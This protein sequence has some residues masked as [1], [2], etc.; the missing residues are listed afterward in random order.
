MNYH[1]RAL[2]ELFWFAGVAVVT[3]L[4]QTFLTFEPNEIQDWRLWA[5][6][7]GAAAVRAFAGAAIAWL[8]KNSLTRAEAKEEPA[9]GFTKS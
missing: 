5:V 3:V 9:S 7:L 1:Y 6:G 8:G 4:L 2:Q